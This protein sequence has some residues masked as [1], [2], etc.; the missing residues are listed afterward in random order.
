MDNIF[1][2]IV[3][4]NG[5]FIHCGFSSSRNLMVILDVAPSSASFVNWKHEA[6]NLL[7]VCK[8]QHPN[9]NFEIKEFK[10]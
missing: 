3:G 6:I 4:G 5:K 9:E 7:E 1:F 8:E 2:G 10:Y